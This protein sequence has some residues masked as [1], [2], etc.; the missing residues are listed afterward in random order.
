ML[1]EHRR[2]LY[3]AL[4][5][6]RDRLVVCGFENRNGVKDGSWYALAKT[7]AES[8]GVALKRG[9]DTFH[10]LGDT[11]D[12]A[13]EAAVAPAAPQ[14]RKSKAGCANRP[15]RSSPRRA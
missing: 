15:R 6:A 3:V 1:E 13:T 5:R 4:T 7:A 10:V 11:S 12:D 2:L 14:T 8:I 9:E